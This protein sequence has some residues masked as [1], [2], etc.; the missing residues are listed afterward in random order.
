MTADVSLSDGKG[1]SVAAA[2]QP[3]WDW[4]IQVAYISA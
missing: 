4:E 2:G 3:A 1:A